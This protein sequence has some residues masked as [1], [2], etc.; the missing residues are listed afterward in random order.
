MSKPT[1]SQ[2]Q[3][4]IGASALAAV[5]ALAAPAQ[6]GPSEDLEVTM[7]VADAATDVSGSDMSVENDTDQPEAEDGEHNDV[8]DADVNDGEH[9]DVDDGDV[10]GGDHGDVDDG[11][12]D[13]EDQNEGGAN[14]SEGGGSQ[15]D[16]PH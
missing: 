12:V 5:F 13:Q 2:F 15:G 3:L 6:A 8:D 14:D 16:G 1:K 10:D 7:D 11:E 9:G 4:L